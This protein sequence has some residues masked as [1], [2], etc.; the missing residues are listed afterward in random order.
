MLWGVS[1][2][3]TLAVSAGIGV[4]LMFSPMALGSVGA[5]ADSNQLMGAL[6][7]TNS[8]IV[9]AEVL[10]PGRFLNAALGLWVVASPWILSGA[11]P[12]SHVTSVIAGLALMLLAI[13]LGPVRE[14]YDGWDVALRWPASDGGQ[15]IPQRHRGPAG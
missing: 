11:S 8:V 5:A 6:V 3:W 13:P 4:W 9:M 1:V 15:P 10:R 2:P 12:V 7:V 14:R